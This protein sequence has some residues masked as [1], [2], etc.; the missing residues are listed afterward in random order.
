MRRH[1]PATGALLAAL[2]ASA[3]VLAQ[4]LDRDVLRNAIDSVVYLRMDRSF[5]NAYF[6][7][8]SSART[9]TGGTTATPCPSAAGPRSR[10]GDGRSLA[11]PNPERR[12][13]WRRASWRRP[14]SEQPLSS[15][16]C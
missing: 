16:S 2:T 11:E 6:T 7:T 12:R 10:S 4:A 13:R 3:P 8:S 9:T 14:V 15:S 1:L 5:G